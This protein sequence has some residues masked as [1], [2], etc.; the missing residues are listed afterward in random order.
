MELPTKVI[1]STTVNPSLLTVFG[2]SKVGKTTM[3]SKLNNCLIIDTE[4]G[5]KYVD[6]LK[7]Q[8]NNSAELKDTVRALK[9]SGSQYNYLALDTIDNVV[10]WFEKD[11][12][13]DN[14]VDSFAKIPFGDGYNQVR[15]RV[16]NMISAL[17]DCCDHIIIIGHRKKT[18]IGNESVEVNVSSLDLSGK[19]KN[20]VMAKSDAIGFV[21]RDEEGHLKISFEASDEIEAGTRLPH[22]A[23]KILDFKWSEIYKTAVGK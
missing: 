12:A 3:L 21:Y 9:E 20:Y 11:V 14:N 18:I 7:V 22:L 10:S 13:R 23:G 16:M 4:K 8:V 6:A 15:T 19:L 5:T 1:K 17:M 2:Q